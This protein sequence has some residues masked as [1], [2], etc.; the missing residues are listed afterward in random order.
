MVC[1][2]VGMVGNLVLTAG[3]IGVGFAASSSALVAD[4]FHSLADVVSD[5]GII[6]V[7]RT[8]QRPADRNHPYGHHGFETLGALGISALIVPW[9]YTTSA[10]VTRPSRLIRLDAAKLWDLCA[11]DTEL[12]LGLMTE[13]AQ[14]AMA[15]L[16]ATRVQ[17]AG[18]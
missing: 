14:A 10:R 4:G 5:V 9:R 2:V 3:K 8:S 17:L 12:A 13:V 15:R 1:T 11:N 6:L 7:L 16:H 18:S